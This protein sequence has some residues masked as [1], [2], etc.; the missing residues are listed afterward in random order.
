MITIEDSI[1]V[2]TVT[3][4]AK[5]LK[6]GRDTVYKWCRRGV[7]AHYKLDGVRGAVRIRLSDVQDFL[8]QRM[9]KR[10]SRRMGTF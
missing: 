7:L 8:K 1:E 6:V 4:V 10:S 3:Q 2:L 9:V 5:A